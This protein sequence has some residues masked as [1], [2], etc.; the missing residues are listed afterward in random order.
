MLKKA[1]SVLPVSA[2]K[3]SRLGQEISGEHYA[4]KGD[5]EHWGRGVSTGQAQQD[6]M[7]YVWT[8]WYRGTC[9]IAF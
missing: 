7:K 9:Y 8:S 2:R 5:R 3:D 6:G 1:V 4:Q